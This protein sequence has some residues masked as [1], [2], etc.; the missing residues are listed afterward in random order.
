MYTYNINELGNEL[1]SSLKKA[2]KEGSIIIKNDEGIL[3]ELKSY[4]KKDSPLDIDGIN[5][6]VD[7]EEIISI[8]KE[9]R[10]KRN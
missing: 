4:F 7:K 6:P 9:S 8:I 5:L 2:Q 3:F 10:K 1:S